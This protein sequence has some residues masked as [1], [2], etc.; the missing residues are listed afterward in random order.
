MLIC[1]F[2]AHA[3]TGP[4]SDSAPQR[5]SLANSR[6]IPSG[7][8]TLMSQ[9]VMAPILSSAGL[10]LTSKSLDSFNAAK[11]YQTYDLE[12]EVSTGQ[13]TTEI[14]EKV[15]KPFQGIPQHPRALH[16]SMVSSCWIAG[17]KSVGLWRNHL[18]VSLFNFKMAT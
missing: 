6:D 14:S 4:T 10:K 11:P 18:E 17:T 15:C 5:G 2:K 12:T 7:C 16:T 8:W 13:K 9:D 1:G 3:P